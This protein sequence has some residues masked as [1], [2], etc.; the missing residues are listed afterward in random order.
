MRL[1]GSGQ[2]AGLRLRSEGG[3]VGVWVLY[4]SIPWGE[5]VH[6]PNFPV[7]FHSFGY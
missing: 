4:R 2:P 1:G 5:T 3:A 7:G 6:L